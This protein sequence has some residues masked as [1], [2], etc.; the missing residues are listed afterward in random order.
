MRDARASGLHAPHALC[1]LKV[2]LGLVD[3]WLR[4]HHRPVSVRPFA[5][6]HPKMQPQRIAPIQLVGLARVKR[7]KTS[8]SSRR[9]LL[10]SHSQWSVG[11]HGKVARAEFVNRWFVNAWFVNA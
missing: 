2:K 1:I 6:L 4:Q 5:L 3:E 7:G 9:D 10:D 11:A 8:R